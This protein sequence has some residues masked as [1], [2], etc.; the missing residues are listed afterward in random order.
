MPVLIIT[1]PPHWRFGKL[2]EPV[3]CPGDCVPTLYYCLYFCA[4]AK[5]T[6]PPET[7]PSLLPTPSFIEVELTY[8]TVKVLGLQCIYCE[9]IATIKLINTSVT[10]HNYQFFVCDEQ[11]DVLFL[12]YKYSV[13]SLHLKVAFLEVFSVQLFSFPNSL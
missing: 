10:S 1:L 9:I 8:N 5:V 12:L 7:L 2:C 13:S 4:S 11:K 3:K 6:L